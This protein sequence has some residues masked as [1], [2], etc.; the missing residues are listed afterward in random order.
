MGERIKNGVL[1]CVFFTNWSPRVLEKWGVVVVKSWGPRVLRVPPAPRL[2]HR[3]AAG[4]AEG[5]RLGNRSL[6][7]L[8][9]SIHP[10]ISPFSDIKG[11]A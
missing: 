4:L 6:L 10:V 11:K 1:A 7:S 9:L 8:N 5:R 2:A 3:A